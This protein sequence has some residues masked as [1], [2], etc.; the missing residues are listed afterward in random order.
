MQRYAGILQSEDIVQS[1][2][3]HN[4]CPAVHSIV[5]KQWVGRC[6]W[7][8][9]TWSRASKQ[10]AL[11]RADTT[12][13]CPPSEHSG[14]VL[15]TE[16]RDTYSIK[17]MIRATVELTAMTCHLLIL[18]LHLITCCVYCSIACLFSR[19]HWYAVKRA[20]RVIRA[21]QSRCTWSQVWRVLLKSILWIPGSLQVNTVTLSSV[22]T[23]DR[24]VLFSLYLK[25]YL[26][27]QKHGHY[28]VNPWSQIMFD[29]RS[30]SAVLSENM[31]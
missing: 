17:E 10:L 8:P 26:H 31:E 24:R 22:S 12:G 2:A 9:V 18:L 29:F 15:F 7:E 25:P 28:R 30:N 21:E 20:R 23:K 11:W 5:W 19:A 3:I 1:A 14:T 6:A 13:I 16:R 27:P 4:T